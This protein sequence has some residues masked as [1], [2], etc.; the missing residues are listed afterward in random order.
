MCCLA[1]DQPRSGMTGIAGSLF[2]GELPALQVA[3]ATC[4][5]AFRGRLPCWSLTGLEGHSLNGQRK[6]GSVNQ[7][8]EIFNTC[9]AHVLICTN[10]LSLPKGPFLPWAPGRVSESLSFCRPQAPPLAPGSGVHLGL[11]AWFPSLPGWVGSAGPRQAQE[12]RWNSLGAGNRKL[13][14][15]GGGPTGSHVGLQAHC[16][17]LGDWV[18]LVGCEV[19]SLWTAV[20]LLQGL[21]DRRALTEL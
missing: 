9:F 20:F 4:Q 13:F 7:F 1:F 5:G 3:A 6:V 2:G 8:S 10:L 14:F 17:F 18:F 19:P 21:H 11:V 15:G 16:A 12:A